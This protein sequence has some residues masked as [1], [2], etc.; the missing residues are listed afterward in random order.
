M[1]IIQLNVWTGRIKGA[2]ERFFR[3]NEAAVVC[4]QEAV[5]CESGPGQLSYIVDTVDKLKEAGDYQYDYRTANF[6]VK[7]RDSDIL[8]HGNVILS[9]IPISSSETKFVYGEY[10]EKMDFTKGSDLI[11][12]AQKVVLEN[13]VVVV[14][15][16]GYWE[17]NPIG[18]EKH[19]ECMRQVADMIRDENRPVI[20]CGDLNVNPESPAMRELDFLHDLTAEYH[21][22]QTLQNLKFIKEVACDHIL[23]ND[24]IKV[25]DYRT[26]DQLTSDHKAL[27]V[28]VELLLG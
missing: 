21:I 5:W 17:T 24:K 7:F 18:G 11:Y 6:G 10:T 20:V 4:L 22:T 3:E 12:S 1:R 14:N 15:Y 2:L 19:V 16:H 26:I 8:K 13:G 9:K 25:N 27:L 28:D 23:V